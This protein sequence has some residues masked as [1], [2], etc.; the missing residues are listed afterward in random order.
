MEVPYKIQYAAQRLREGHR[1]NRITVRDFLRHFGAERRGAAKVEAIREILDSLGLQT[2]PGF[3]TAWIDEPIWLRLK[4]SSASTEEIAAEPAA[5]PEDEEFVLE[6]TPSA[7]EQ[8]V[9]QSEAAPTSAEPSANEG[10]ADSDTTDPTFRIGSL[11]AA[12]KTLI[13]VN[14]NDDVARA[15]TLMMQ[16]DFS[17][18]PVMQGEREVKGVV[19]WKSIGLRKVL[20]SKCERVGDCQDDARIVD[21][22][23]TLFDSIP[24]IVEY[25]YVLVRQHDR[26]ITGIVTASDLSLQFQILAEPFLLLREIELHVRQIIRGKITTEDCVFLDNPSPPNQPLQDIADLT[27]GEYVRLFEHPQIWGK[28][29]LKIDRVVLTKLLDDVRKVRND[30]MHFDP[31]PMTSD[32][33]AILKRAVRLMQEVYT[34]AP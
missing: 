29:N 19:T 7:V 23:R 14:Q 27:F 9:E 24:F 13:T 16:Y 21:A 31:D 26:R 4:G 28:L 10:S 3:E 17:Q 18:L 25:G 11:P 5:P 2:E 33:L 6:G 32:E 20:G 34:L 12:N 1:V 15:V 8:A 30:V 22:N